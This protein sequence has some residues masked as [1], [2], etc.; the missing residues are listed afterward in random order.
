M[1]LASAK[2]KAL[3]VYALLELTIFIIIPTYQLEKQW[4]KE[5]EILFKDIQRMDK[6]LTK[7][8]S[9]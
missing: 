2:D 9:N 4:I 8:N 7:V 6:E 5:K 1:H 3:T